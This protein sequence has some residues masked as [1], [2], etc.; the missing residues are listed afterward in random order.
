MH[1]RDSDPTA[2]RAAPAFRVWPPVSVSLPWLIGYTAGR[3]GSGAAG[4]SGAWRTT[5]EG[6]GWLLLGGVA[7]WSGSCLLLFATR[8]TGLLPGQPTSTLLA[9][10]PYRWTRNPLYVG[11]LAGYVALALIVGSWWALLLAP[12]A[13]AGLHWG[14]VL[15]EERYLETR[16][17]EPYQAYCRRVRRWL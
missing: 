17:G 15:P 4:W 7:V 13:W 14:A 9:T 1:P 3:L 8:R 10:G 2:P 16:L 11:M 6:I 5:L 12:V